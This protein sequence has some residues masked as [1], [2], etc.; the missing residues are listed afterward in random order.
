MADSLFAPVTLAPLLTTLAPL[1]TT[2]PSPDLVP[3]VS[4][5]EVAMV[6]SSLEPVMDSMDN[7]DSLQLVASVINVLFQNGNYSGTKGS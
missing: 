1:L 2:L 6:A 7:M 3:E 5:E 4:M